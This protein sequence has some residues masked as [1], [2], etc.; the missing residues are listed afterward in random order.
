[1]S[2]RKTKVQADNSWLPPVDPMDAETIVL[3]EGPWD[4]ETKVVQRGI[5]AFVIARP[6]DFT[7]IITPDDWREVVYTQ[8]GQYVREEPLSPYFMWKGWVT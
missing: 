6:I 3:L 1:M 2:D 8:K 4:M 7:A 5:Q